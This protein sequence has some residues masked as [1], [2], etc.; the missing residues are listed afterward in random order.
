MAHDFN[1]LLTVISGYSEL[2]LRMLPANDPKRE[3]ILAISEA[4]ERAAGLTRQLLFFSRQA[5]LETKVLD[6]N[7]VV[8]DAEKMLRRMIGEDILLAAVLD[9][10]ISRI[11]GDAGQ[12][13]QILVNLAVNARDAMPQGGNLTIET[14]NVELDEGYAA[15]H[16]EC[17][18][19]RYVKLAVSDNGCGMTPEVK[20]HVFE[21]FFTTKEVGKGTG[22]GLATVFG[23]VKQS[24]GTINLYTEPGH[25]TTF[26]IYLPAIDEPLRPSHHDQ[27][28]AKVTGGAETILLVEDDDAVRAIARLFLQNQGYTV[29][30]AENGKRALAIIETHRGRID[31]LMTDVVMPGMSGRQLAETLGARYPGIKVLYVSGYTD[32]SVIRHGILQVEVAFLQKPYRPQA[33]ARKVREV[34]DKQRESAKESG[35][36][37]GPA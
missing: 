18:P 5:M 11:K 8:K 27:H 23:I 19:G 15:Q 34:M 35:L 4:A 36:D 33:L 14:S 20:A 21:P 16:S 28:A 10:N 17:T 29:L 25:G 37:Q 2:V 24:G 26:K 12:I 13:G 7:E 9:P 3:A 22:L 6:L 1:N 32:D 31:L 30:Q